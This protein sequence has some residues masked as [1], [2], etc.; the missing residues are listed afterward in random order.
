[1]T[2]IVDGTNGLTFPNSTTQASAGTVLQVLQ[3]VKT[4]T[5]STS[6]TSYVDITG[7]SVS[8]T[9]KFSTSKILVMYQLNTGV[10]TAIQ[11]IFMQLVRNSTP[12][13]VGDAA[14]SRPQTTS[15]NGLTNAYGVLDMS[16]SYLDFP[17]TTSATTY[18]IQMMV[19]GGSPYLGYVN[20]G[21]NDRNTSLYDARTASSIIVMEVAG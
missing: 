3:A 20:R 11:G 13:F 4:D 12:I 19:N 16:G 2:F 9:P 14:G 10:D 17:A 15:T 18:K 21:V 6:S 5:F 8:I 7:L 1:M